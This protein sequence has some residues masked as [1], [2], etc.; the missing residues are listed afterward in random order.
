MTVKLNYATIETVNA[1][2]DQGLERNVAETL[3]QQISNQEHDNVYSVKEIDKMMAETVREVFDKSDAKFE[4]FRKE[5]RR[6]FD[7]VLRKHKKDAWVVAGTLGSTILVG[8][9]SVAIAVYFG[10]K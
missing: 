1:L 7:D 4:A 8:F 2:I 10:L 9:I 5:Q 6:E 3:V